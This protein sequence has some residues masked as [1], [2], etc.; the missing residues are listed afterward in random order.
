MPSYLSLSLLK[1]QLGI[2]NTAQDTYLNLILNS[3]EANIKNYLGY[4]PEET[5]ILEYADGWGTHTIYLRRSPVDSIEHVYEDEYGYYGQGTNAFQ[6]TSELTEGV[7]YVMAKDHTNNWII[8]RINRVWPYRLDRQPG[9]VTSTM[10]K[11][12]GCVKIEYTVDNTDVMYAC[13]QAGQLESIARF[14]LGLTGTGV[15]TADS[16]DGASVSINNW[17][18]NPYN[19][20]ADSKDQFISPIVSTL[21]HPFRAATSFFVSS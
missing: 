13:N 14:R 7:D 16:M 5:D 4:D 15:V 19:E 12:P 17:R 20:R 1:T 2:T 6:S 21:L 8:R 9:A 10:G 11:C 18:R 3:T